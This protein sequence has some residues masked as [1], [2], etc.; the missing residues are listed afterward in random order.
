M[1]TGVSPP[2]IETLLEVAFAPAR[3]LLVGRKHAGI[4]EIHVPMLLPPVIERRTQVM[5]PGFAHDV[6]LL[7][8]VMPFVVQPVEGIKAV[9][10]Y[11]WAVIKSV[12]QV[13]SRLGSG[14][15]HTGI[16]APSAVITILIVCH[17]LPFQPLFRIPHDQI[18]HRTADMIPGRS[19]VNDLHLC[20]PVRRRTA[21]QLL[22][23]F[24]SQRGDLPVHQDRHL[25][26]PLQS[27]GFSSDR[28][29]RQSVQQFPRIVCNVIFQ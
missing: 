23:L 2:L 20:H 18:D 26:C 9:M 25:L 27:H 28:N 3:R 17:K 15:T 8:D 5:R 13:K 1:Q 11:M 22:Q 14:V 21:Q 19:I 7:T 4:S 12:H 10:L 16:H 24:R 6:L 29:T